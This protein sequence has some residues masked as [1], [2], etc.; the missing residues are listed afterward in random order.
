MVLL[1]KR[2]CQFLTTMVEPSIATALKEVRSN[3]NK[4]YTEYRQKSGS[5]PGVEPCLIAV[6][7]TKPVEMLEEAYSSGQKD[8]GENYVQELVQKAN[9]LKEKGGYE[10]IRWHFIGKLQRNKV[11]NL[12][13]APN[14]TCVQTVE[15]IKLAT[16][17]NNSWSK[18]NTGEEKLKVYAQINS[19]GE[20]SK[21]GCNPSECID[22]VRHILHDCQS[23]QF[24]GLMTIGS[25]SHDYSLGPNP[26]FQVLAGL[27]EQLEQEF[28]LKKE[29]VRLSMGMSNDYQQAILAG[30][31]TIRVGS[32][33]F[34]KREY[35]EK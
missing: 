26:D 6:S 16:A 5:E 12:L 23:L 25:F 22:L 1:P 11:N 10:D 32:T 8:F 17:I 35:K 3:I 27:R 4:A 18:R 29:D 33:I 13:G 9:E 31:S 2:G 20:E 28:D 19:S 15:S 24:E 21:S 34:G 7:K 14:L 30:A